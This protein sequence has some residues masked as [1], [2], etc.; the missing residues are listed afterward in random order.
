[1][2]EDEEIM[3][4]LIKEIKTD[5]DFAYEDVEECKDILQ[6]NINPKFGME[7]SL[8]LDALRT[9]Q[10]KVLEE[11]KR[12][13][14][15]GN[16]TIIHGPN[17]QGKTSLLE[18]IRFNLLGL[19]DNNRIRLVDPVTD[20]FSTLTTDGYWSV[21]G[22]EFLVRRILKDSGGYIQHDQVRLVNEPPSPDDSSP[23][24]VIS[25]GNPQSERDWF[26]KF[27]FESLESRNFGRYNLFSL[28]FLMSAD[29]KLFLDWQG[30][31]RLLDLLFG[32]N[33]SGVT[34]EVERRIEND[35]ELEEKE[36]EAPSK[37]AQAR[38]DIDDLQSKTSEIRENLEKKRSVLDEKK[39]ELESVRNVLQGED[40]LEELRTEKSRVLRRINRL[41]D[42]KFEKKDDLRNIEQDISRY[43]ERELS[44]EIGPLAADLQQLMAV[45]ES[46]PICAN[47]VDKEQKERLVNDA[48][49]P[50]CAKPVKDE[51]HDSITET[52][53][54]DVPLQQEE[55]VEEL[56][57]LREEKRRIKGEIQNLEGQVDSLEDR[58]EDIER[59][60]DTSDISDYV[61]RR[62]ELESK[63]SDL[64]SEVTELTVNL[65][66]AKNR[67]EST[68][69]EL[70]ELQRLK[71]EHDRKVHKQD[72]LNKFSS[73]VTQEVRDE[74]RVIHQNLEEIMGDLLDTH[75]TQGLFENAVDVQFDEDGEYDF[76]IYRGSGDAKPSTRRNSETTEGVIQGLLFHTAVLKHLSERSSDLPI[77]LF[78]IDAPFSNEPDENN[79]SDIA[80]LLISLPE[81]LDSYQLIITMAD[82]EFI[83]L[84]DFRPEYT[85]ISI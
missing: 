20:G 34:H 55:R 39:D 72:I 32:I 22:S 30:S 75:F 35:Y 84:D 83:N 58:I 28:F 16:N 67:L 52:D 59:R 53:G 57:K 54:E 43:E 76:T 45:P 10:F 11:P 56:E 51:R 5:N 14:F 37:L 74:R 9:K 27:G 18:A 69:N 65:D 81:I 4:D 3:E 33:L 26:E 60:I 70:D 17:S 68:K 38:S 64:E 61:E 49:C 50:L 82:S 66:S 29:Y 25:F 12:F 77:R 71:E 78:L 8:T 23:D 46:C 24:E 36:E 85:T 44:R 21:D 48:K 47:E 2:R 31:T 19:Q 80:S 62:D 41:E 1:M 79:A 40:Q 13:N 73:L 6:E 63:V 42:E 7:G 15:S